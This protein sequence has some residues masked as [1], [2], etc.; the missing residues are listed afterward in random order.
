V[1][2][3][4]ERERERESEREEETNKIERRKKNR[5]GEIN[6]RTKVCYKRNSKEKQKWKH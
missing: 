3:E 5:G 6:K 2:R 4:R 1:E